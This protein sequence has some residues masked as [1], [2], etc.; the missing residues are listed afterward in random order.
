MKIGRLKGRNVA[1]CDYKQ[2][3]HFKEEVREEL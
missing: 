2:S 1:H 3:T